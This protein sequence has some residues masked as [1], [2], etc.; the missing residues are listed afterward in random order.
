MTS[1]SEKAR[2]VLANILAHQTASLVAMSSGAIGP[3]G[4]NLDA[5]QLRRRGVWLRPG[6]SGGGDPKTWKFGQAWIVLGSLDVGAKVL[7][8]F[9]ASLVQH[10]MGREH[11]QGVFLAVMHP[12]NG[13][14][15]GANEPKQGD[16]EDGDSDQQFCHA[17]APACSR[18]PARL[19]FD[20][21]QHCH[22][23]KSQLGVALRWQLWNWI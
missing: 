18:L 2:S 21:V 17:H 7:A 8:H 9:A 1:S 20:E 22:P 15:L 11:S 23:E 10:L 6:P 13:K 16:A 12:G 19:S 4:K 3:S 14:Q 5:A